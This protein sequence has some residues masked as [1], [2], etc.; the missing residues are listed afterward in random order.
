MKPYNTRLKVQALQTLYK[1]I[2]YDVL[3]LKEKSSLI[4]YMDLFN[5]YYDLL[6]TIYE[7]QSHCR[8]SFN[9]YTNKYYLM[10]NDKSYKTYEEVIEWVKNHPKP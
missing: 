2:T 4:T 7:R 5:K 9:S 6:I 8:C 1:C 10:I 3:N